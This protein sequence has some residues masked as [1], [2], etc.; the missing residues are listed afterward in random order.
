[1]KIV[2]VGTLNGHIDCGD[3]STIFTMRDPLGKIKELGSPATSFLAHQ[4]ETLV[5]RVL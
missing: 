3:L 1:M 2:T 4:H 5:V